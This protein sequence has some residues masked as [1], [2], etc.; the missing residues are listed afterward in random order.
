MSL[1]YTKEEG[2]KVHSSLSINDSYTDLTP[3]KKEIIRYNDALVGDFVDS[4]HNL[5]FKDS[6]LLK[7]TKEKCPSR[8]ILKGDD[9]VFVSFF[10]LL[11]FR[12]LNLTLE[13]A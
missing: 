12:S 4:F 10:A 1:S 11:N 8:F 9:D 3:L 5:T 2:F 13:D 7:W 6:M